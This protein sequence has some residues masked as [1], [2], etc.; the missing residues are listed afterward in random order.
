MYILSLLILLSSSLDECDLNNTCNENAK[1]MGA[2]GNY[3]CQCNE[4]YDGNG[5]NCSGECTEELTQFTI[6]KVKLLLLGS[7][8]LCIVYYAFA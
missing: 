7:C 1:C 3:T 5:F 2:I 4:G 8:L 6:I